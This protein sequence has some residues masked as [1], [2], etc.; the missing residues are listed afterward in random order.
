VILSYRSIASWLNEFVIVKP[1]ASAFCCRRRVIVF[2]LRLIFGGFPPLKNGENVPVPKKNVRYWEVS[3]RGGFTAQST[4]CSKCYRNTVNTFLFKNMF[5]R[6][7]INYRRQL[8]FFVFSGLGTKERRRLLKRLY[9]EGGKPYRF[10]MGSSDRD[11]TVG[12]RDA[13]SPGASGTP[14]SDG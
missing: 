7:I 8:G 12:R 1:N 5:L 6:Q 4:D 13:Y 11:N 9:P 10:L 14:E 2:K 3:V